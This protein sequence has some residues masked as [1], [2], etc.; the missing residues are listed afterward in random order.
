MLDSVIH[1]ATIVQTLDSAIQRI[2]NRETNCAIHWIDFYPVDSAFQ[3]LNNRGQINHYPT[4]KYYG[5]QYC[6]IH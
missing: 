3:R 6:Y 5:N 4:A 1:Q 2:S